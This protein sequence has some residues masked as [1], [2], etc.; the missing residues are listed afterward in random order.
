MRVCVVFNP[1]ARGDRAVRF[2]QH[3]ESIASDC[4]LKPTLAAG[5]GRA[6]AAEAA[7][8]GFDCIVAAGGDGTMN[9]VL[10]GIADVPGG[11]DRVSLAVLPLGTAN[12]F[13]RELGLPMNWQHAWAKIRKG[14]TRQLD[15]AK[16]TFN[17]DTVAEQRFFVQLAGAGLDARAVQLVDWTWKKRTGFVA[18]V[19]AALRALREPQPRITVQTA[20]ETV[21]GELVLIGNGQRYG[22]PFRLFRGADPVDG[23]LDVLVYDR[24]DARLALAGLF[25]LVTGR[26]ARAGQPRRIKTTALRLNAP[27]ATPFQVDGECVGCLPVEV[28]IQP[29]ALRAIVP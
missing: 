19:T 29:L 5:G 16:V 3:L 4:A 23:L 25:G 21:S 24:V 10:N 12:V 6:L 9:E 15:L 18:Y 14:H 7:H 22:G 11:L 27:T 26:L 13:A 8:H 2:R 1:T 17:T 28:T 20:D